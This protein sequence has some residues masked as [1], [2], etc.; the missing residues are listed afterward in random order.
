[1]R[2]ERWRDKGSRTEWGVRAGGVTGRGTG[3]RSEG[4]RDGILSKQ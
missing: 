3:N 4:T 2:G 1:M